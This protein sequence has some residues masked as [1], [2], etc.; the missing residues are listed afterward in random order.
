MTGMIRSCAFCPEPLAFR[1]PTPAEAEALGLGDLARAWRHP[2]GSI[3]KQ[4]EATCLSCRGTGQRLS[5]P[6]R[7][8]Y[9]RGDAVH[10]S[11]Y[12]ECRRCWG[13]GREQVD[14]HCATAVRS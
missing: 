8:R 9:E 3:Y 13:T 12:E 4:R 14:D 11:D 5:T 2:D 10:G 7:S 6:A 1:A